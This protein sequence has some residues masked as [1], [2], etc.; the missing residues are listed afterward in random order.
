MMVKDRV[1]PGSGA[2]SI[3]SSH[4]VTLGGFSLEFSKP[5]FLHWGGTITRT[6]SCSPA[7][8]SRPSHRAARSAWPCPQPPLPS[9][10]ATTYPLRGGGVASVPQIV[11]QPVTLSTVPSSNFLC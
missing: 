1:S 11:Q 10:S 5:Q 6:T 9:L 2:L 4:L 7:A 3:D 8:Q